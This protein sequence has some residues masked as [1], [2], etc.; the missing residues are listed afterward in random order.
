MIAEVLYEDA[1]ITRVSEGLET[2]GSLGPVPIERTLAQLKTYV[3]AARDLGARKLACVATAGLRGADGAAAFIDAAKTRT[4]IDVE[5]IDGLRE[6]ELSFSAP[7]ARY[8]TGTIAVVDVGGRSTEIIIGRRGAIDGRVSLP[9]GGVRLTERF[10]ESDPPSPEALGACRDH[11]AAVLGEAPR[12][13]Q[14]EPIGALIGV[15]GTIMS[16]LGVQLGLTEMADVIAHEGSVLRR[17]SVRATLQTLATQP[18]AQRVR[19]S[20]IPSGRADV[21]VA[22]AIVVDGILEHFAATSM[23]ASQL[24]VRYGLLYEMALQS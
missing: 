20:V 9:L 10:F 7:S 3:D 23:I 2:T 1:K 14:S 17:E 5:I 8:G 13:T 6:A 24:G 16:L 19:G 22:A 11:V 21:I 15:S 18:A 4:G 12:A